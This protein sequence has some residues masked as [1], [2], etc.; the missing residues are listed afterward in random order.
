MSWLTSAAYLAFM[1]IFQYAAVSIAANAVMKRWSWIALSLVLVLALV[2]S[3]VSLWCYLMA[4]MEVPGRV[5][6][7]IA[8]W[9]VNVDV[10]AAGGASGGTPARGGSVFRLYSHTPFVFA[11]LPAVGFCIGLWARSHVVLDAASRLRGFAGGRQSA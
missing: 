5:S 2:C 1:V 7:N 11:S 10:G 3:F 9:L 8:N 4:W 6:W